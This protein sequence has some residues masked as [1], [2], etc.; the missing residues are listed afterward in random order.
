LHGKRFFAEEFCRD[1][2]LLWLPDAFGYSAAL[3]QIMKGCRVKY[4]ATAKLAWNYNAD[5]PFP[6]TNFVWEGLDGSQ[7]LAHICQSYGL[8]P[9][10]SSIINCWQSSIR[11]GDFPSILIPFGEGDGGGGAGRDDL[12][13]LKRCENLE[14]MPNTKIG[15]PLELFRRMEDS[16]IPHPK[17]VG[18]LYFAGH[19]GTYTS[20]ARTKRGNRTCEFALREA[21]F[22]GIATQTLTNSSYAFAHMDAL[23]K[24]LLLNQFHDI[25]PGSAMQRVHEEAETDLKDILEKASVATDAAIKSLCD[26]SVTAVTVFNSL[27]WERCCLIE[28]PEHFAAAQTAAA[29]SLPVQEVKGKKIVEV[30]IPSCGWTTVFPSQNPPVPLFNLLVCREQRLENE[31]LRLEFNEY[32]EIVILFDKEIGL[33]LTLGPCNSFKMY[34]DIPS[35]HD[36][37]DIDSMY[38]LQPVALNEPAVFQVITTGP[39]VAQMS[40][41]RI[42]NNSLLSQVVSLRRDSRRIDFHTTINWQERHKLLKVAFP[43]RIHTHFALHEIQFGHLARPNH[44]SM[45]FDAQQFEVSQQK[46]TAITEE[47]RGFAILNDCKYGIGL[48]DHSLELTLPRAPIAPAKDADLGVQEFAYACYLWNGAFAS[49]D[50]IREAYDLNCRVQTM[51]GAGGEKCLISIDASNII[52]ETMKPAQDGSQDVIIRLYES[53]RMWTRSILHANMPFID[54]F[55]TDLL[56]TREKHL[57]QQKGCLMLE[58]RPFE[59]KT[60]RL[61]R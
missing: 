16:E 20:Q 11:K 4:L 39:L 54:A 3:P 18:E 31:K 47:N 61:A 44:R 8:F 42:L 10:P 22:W 41:T 52:L 17:F 40:I 55:E 24:K 43:V 6:Y 57:R 38:K 28:L 13:Y 19:R 37:W 60:I 45:P 14:E 23:W 58:F 9:N 51:A 34:K 56:E 2:I 21:E 35:A 1:S 32:G 15:S 36:A 46:W 50:V 12:E 25:L 7:V 49:S 26:A 27:S 30:T 59:I 48:T 53:K 33:E 29:S 5:E